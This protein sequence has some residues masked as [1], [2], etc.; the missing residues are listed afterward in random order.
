[1]A[2][3]GPRPPSP[4]CCDLDRVAFEARR[5]EISRVCDLQRRTERRDVAKRVGIYASHLNHPYTQ[6]RGAKWP[7]RKM[8]DSMRRR[9]TVLEGAVPEQEVDDV[10]FVR[11]QP[12]EGDRLQRADVEPV[13]IRRVQKLLREFRVL[14]NRRADERLADRAEHLLLWAV[15]HRHERKH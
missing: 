1:G 11:L 2:P 14:R 5:W 3:T 13:D 10:A 8:P 9:G 12:V 7:R 15:D 4:N 6:S